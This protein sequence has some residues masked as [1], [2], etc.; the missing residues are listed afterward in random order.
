MLPGECL[1]DRD[2]QGCRGRVQRRALQL[3]SVWSCQR[4]VDGRAMLRLNSSAENGYT[5][6]TGDEST[7]NGREAVR[8]G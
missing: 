5:G 2:D 8:R 7:D 6:P 1:G 3:G 4:H